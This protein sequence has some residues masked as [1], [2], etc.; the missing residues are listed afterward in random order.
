MDA[1][2]SVSPKQKRYS[3]CGIEAPES[4]FPWKDRAR[5]LRRTWCRSCQ[6]AY[7]HDHYLTNIDLYKAKAHKAS[8]GDRKRLRMLVTDYLKVNPCVDC[9]E[10]DASV[11]E[12]DHRD[13]IL[14]RMAV[15]RLVSS[16]GWPTVE[17][18]IAK[19]DVRC[20]NCHRRRTARQ[21][22]WARTKDLGAPRPARPVETVER[23]AEIG[24]TSCWNAPCVA[25]FCHRHISRS[26][27][28]KG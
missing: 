24:A 15:S 5:G 2:H 26:A 23:P 20:A 7:A 10:T 14:K 1:A 17:R 4:D 27:A 12:F 16:A 3:R 8:P 6:R 13:P 9:G 22:N 19:C 28:L 25:G 11:L 21:F 18:E